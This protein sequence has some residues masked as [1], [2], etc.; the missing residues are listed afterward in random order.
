MPTYT[1]KSPINHDGKSYTDGDPIEL[2][3]AAARPLLAAGA[4]EPA[5]KLSKEEEQQR[6]TEAAQGQS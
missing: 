3:A 2:S 6:R 5:K 4:V 1:V